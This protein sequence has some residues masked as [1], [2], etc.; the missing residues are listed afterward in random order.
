M[1]EPGSSRSTGQFRVCEAHT[2]RMTPSTSTF[3]A[4]ARA[5]GRTV[6][7]IPPGAWDGTGL[8]EWSV[9][10]LV[11]HTSRALITVIDYLRR[12]VVE[13][14]VESA[15]A[16]LAAVSTGSVDPRAVAER[17]RHAG[18]ELGDDPASRFAQLVGEAIEAAEAADP[19]LVVHTVFGGMRVAAYLPTRTFELC[20]HG[21]DIA[22]ATGAPLD[23]PSA[24]LEET[25]ALAVGAA[26]RSG[27]GA[28][29]LMALTGRRDL[30]RPF[31][32]V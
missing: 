7:D 5:V 26:V 2:E 29:V 10:D 15:S 31:S 4:A 30:P 3:V 28:D 19:D 8:G 21:L 1:T 6:D 24:A 18:R 13:E 17:G 22:T 16:Y 23:L 20:V 14:V 27:R 11:G 25:C 12:P 9:R 32:V